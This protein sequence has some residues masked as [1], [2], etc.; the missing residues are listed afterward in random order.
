MLLDDALLNKIA[1]PPVPVTVPVTTIVVVPSAVS[2]PR[3]PVIEPATSSRLVPPMP[4]LLAID[5][6]VLFGV[7]A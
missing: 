5:K 2:M 6:P 7:S 1:V 4:P 3:D